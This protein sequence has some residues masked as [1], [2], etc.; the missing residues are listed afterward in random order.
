MAKNCCKRFEET[1]K[2]YNYGALC[3]QAKVKD[4]GN[5]ANFGWQKVML[6]T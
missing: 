3:M 6:E 5:F 1:I 4:P 2:F